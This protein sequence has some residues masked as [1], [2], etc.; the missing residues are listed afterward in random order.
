MEPLPDGIAAFEYAPFS[1]LFPRAAAIVHQGGIGT[2]GQALRSGRPAVIVPFSHDQPD[3]AA[4]CERLGVA[5]VVSRR[6]ANAP[7][8]ARAIGEVLESRTIR[9]RARVVG[10]R[11]RSEGG[12]AAA[13]EVVE[14]F[15]HGAVRRGVGAAA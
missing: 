1:E 3:N 2:T 7:R 14:G 9:E 13:A 15:L 8:L 5:R 6:R 4:R 10:D 11:V 12:A